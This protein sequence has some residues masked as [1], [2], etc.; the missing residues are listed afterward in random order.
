M[1]QDSPIAPTT[2]KRKAVPST[3]TEIEATHQDAAL[4]PSEEKGHEMVFI[5]ATYWDSG[6]AHK[7]FAP[8]QKYDG[9]CSVLKVVLDQI[10]LLES[11][12][13]NSTYWHLGVENNDSG[14]TCTAND[15]FLL[16][17]TCMYLVCALHKFV[18]QTNSN[19]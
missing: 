4:V 14:N 5:I 12:K 16:R 18:D 11:V 13:R 19:S 17:C 9:Q 15:I 7:L 3:A 6:D 8:K 10:E 1:Q 2:R